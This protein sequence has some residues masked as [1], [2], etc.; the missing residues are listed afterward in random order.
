VKPYTPSLETTDDVEKTAADWVTRCDAGLTAAEQQIFQDWLGADAR[1][2]DAFDRLSEAWAVFDRAQQGG[3]VSAV[4]AGLEK[5][6][7]QRRARRLQAGVAAA[8]LVSAGFFFAFQGLGPGAAGNGRSQ[9]AAPQIAFDP[10]R[11]LPDG[12]VVELKE[13][14][15]IEVAYSAEARRVRMVRGEAYFRVEKDKSRPFYVEANGVQV[16]AVGTAFSV[17]MQAA[18]VEVVVKEGAVDVGHSSPASGDQGPVR[19][20]AGKRIV[21]SLIRL[22]PALKAASPPP[23]GAVDSAEPAQPMTMTEEELE[24]RLA[25]RLPRLEFE[26]MPLADAVALLNRHNALQITLADPSVGALRISGNFR[27]DNPEGFIRIAEQSL[28]L[29]AEQGSTHQVVL[30]RR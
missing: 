25:W 11:K 14:A 26:G 13:G 6:A 27:A 16:R 19:V 8:L 22:R 24:T 4:L 10:I 1:H 9:L 18:A 29:V 3:V 5:R 15:E 2:A 12:S 23:A 21:M 20:D 17:Q 30:R 28:E 7:R